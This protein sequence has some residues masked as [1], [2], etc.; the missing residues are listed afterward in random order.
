[1]ESEVPI[2]CQWSHCDKE[3]AK[4]LVFGVRVFDASGNV[5]ISDTSQPA[6][7]L[8]LC[9]KHIELISQQYIHVTEYELGACPKSHLNL[10]ASPNHPAS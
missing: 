3:A 2:L 1:M 6:E 7:H 8:D 5:H 4:H 9:I 10:A